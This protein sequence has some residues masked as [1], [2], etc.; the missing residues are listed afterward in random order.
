MPMLGAFHAGERVVICIG[1]GETPD[2]PY[3][4]PNLWL[5]V[6]V[7]NRETKH[8]IDALRQVPAALRFLSLEPLLED[9]GELSLSG[10]AWVIVGGESGPGARPCNTAWIRSIVEQCNAARVPAFCKQ[11]GA[12]VIQN[13][14]RRIKRDKKGGDMHEW[15]HD[16]RVREF[17]HA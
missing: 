7:E 5:G 8:R 12:H 11:L 17:P 9:L 2:R 10:I 4:L 6:S 15:E 16:L 1:D 14:E 3:I 13:G